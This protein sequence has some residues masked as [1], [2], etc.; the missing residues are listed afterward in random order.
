MLITNIESEHLRY[1]RPSS[2]PLRTTLKVK[3]VWGPDWGDIEAFEI[4]AF[5]AFWTPYCPIIKTGVWISK[6]PGLEPSCAG[7]IRSRGPL[8]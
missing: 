1:C 5:R 3:G 4:T 8:R 2:L 7:A 6:R